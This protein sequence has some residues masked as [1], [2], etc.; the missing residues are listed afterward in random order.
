MKTITILS[1]ILFLSF[2]SNSIEFSNKYMIQLTKSD[3]LSHKIELVCQD[4]NDGQKFSIKGFSIKFPGHPVEVIN[5][6]SLNATAQ[7]YMKDLK[8]NQ[9]VSI[10]DIK[11]AYQDEQLISTKDIPSFYIKIK[12]EQNT[13]V[14][15]H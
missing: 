9:M 4:F 5:G 13:V 12:E 2:S 8:A 3:L 15:N 11:S 14:M 1:A 10:F 7:A 6:A